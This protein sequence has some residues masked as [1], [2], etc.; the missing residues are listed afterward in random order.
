MVVAWRA[1]VH[2]G[3]QG[4]W[5]DLLGKRRAYAGHTQGTALQPPV[6]HQCGSVHVQGGA[7]PWCQAHVQGVQLE[8]HTAAVLVVQ[9]AQDGVGASTKGW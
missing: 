7:M 5:G 4:G 3:A 6:Q 9:A 8:N 2:G 1:C